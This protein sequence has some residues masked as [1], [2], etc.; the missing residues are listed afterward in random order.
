[1]ISSQYYSKSPTQLPIS[2]VLR[3]YD[4]MLLQGGYR[5]SEMPGARKL[6][7]FRVFFSGGRGIFP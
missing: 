2:H 5:L 6:S 3:D 1:M 4:V 7:N